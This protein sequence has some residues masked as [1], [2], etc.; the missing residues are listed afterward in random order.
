MNLKSLILPRLQVLL[1][2]NDECFFPAQL[3]RPLQLSDQLAPWQGLLLCYLLSLLGTVLSPHSAFL[4]A[5]VHPSSRCCAEV[6]VWTASIWNIKFG[7]MLEG[8]FTG[9]CQLLEQHIK[10]C[11]KLSRLLCITNIF[12]VKAAKCEHL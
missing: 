6:V 2:C 8:P 4:T 9:P 12:T 3:Y 10:E 1:G 7:V 11:E 5:F